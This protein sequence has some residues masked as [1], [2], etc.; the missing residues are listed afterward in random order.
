VKNGK[1]L[2]VDDAEVNLKIAENFLRACGL[3][4]ECARSGPEAILCITNGR[5]EYDLVFMDFMMEGLDGIET[6][7]KIRNEIG[8]EYAQRVPILAYTD[9]INADNKNNFLDNGFNGFLEKPIR[10]ENLDEVL[11]RWI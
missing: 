9:Q 1:V 4:V 8:T 2:V 6:V 5:D 11:K 3:K 10:K 7:K